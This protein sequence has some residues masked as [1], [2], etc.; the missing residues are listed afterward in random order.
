MSGLLE[1]AVEGLALIERLRVPLEPGF[2]VITGETGAG[3]SLLI[4]AL[5]LVLGGRADPAAVRSGAKLARVE[6]LFERPGRDEPLI[7]VREVAAAG[8]SL[9]RIDDETVTAARLAATA[10]PLIAIHG[11]H[12]QQRLLEAAAQR[13]LLDAYGGH[14]PLRERVAVAVAAWR[15]NRAALDA[16][17][18][19]ADLERRIALA[20]HAA[21]EIEAARVQPGEVAD[22]R[23]ALARLASRE[24]IDR[25]VAGLRARLSDERLGAR[26]VLAVAARE[27][28]ELARLDAR[29]AALAERVESLAAEVDDVA[30]ELGRLDDGEAEGPSAADLETRLGLLYGLLRKYGDDEAHVVAYGQACRA[31]AQ[32]LRQADAQRAERL[33]DDERL[34]AVAREAAAQL[35][36][37]RQ[38][39]GQRLA[40]AAGAALADLGLAGAR[41]SVDLQP[42]ELTPTGA[43]HVTFLLAANP[44]EPERPLA[45]I[46]SG[47]EL[48]RISLAIE[49]VLAGADTTPTLVFDEV[50]AGIGARSADPVGR[51]L[52]RLARDHQVIVV[53]HLA[54][55]AAHAEHHLLIE[56][57]VEEGR[58]LTAVRALDGEHRVHELALMLGGAGRGQPR[59]VAPAGAPSAAALATARE[60]VAGA[61]P[62]T[63]A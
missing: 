2:T 25:L 13:D 44:G 57:R 20:E 42:A 43:E 26:D 11:Q 51:A 28:A 54:Q 16:V 34:E 15:D 41:L 60:L 8:R 3:K 46:A 53:T 12:Q 6:A 10:G 35:S 50:D 52:R 63:T 19:A 22:L 58:T 55:I 23:A 9:A 38:E 18:D 21:D 30:V 5:G 37:A 27:A 7:C 1:L 31:E 59:S 39:A 40:V 45:A 29:R 61:E 36:A 14:E 62:A 33:A 4:D 24:A 47:G 32:E 49:T 17:A 48:S 56:K